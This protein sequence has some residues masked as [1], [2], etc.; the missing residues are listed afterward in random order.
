VNYRYIS[1]IVWRKEPEEFGT[2]RSPGNANI[3][4]TPEQ[5]QV[6]AIEKKL[7]DSES[8]NLRY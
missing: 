5:E 1:T 4:R 6:S 7:K 8:L 3:K 2:G